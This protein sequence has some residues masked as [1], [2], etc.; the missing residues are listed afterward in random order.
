MRFGQ[1]LTSVSGFD[2][3][4]DYTQVTNFVQG[5]D[6]EFPDG[7]E[8]RFYFCTMVMNEI[9]VSTLPRYA[10]KR[11]LNLLTETW[12][13][14]ARRKS[15][16]NLGDEPYW[17]I[18]VMRSWRPMGMLHLMVHDWATPEFSAWVK[19]AKSFVF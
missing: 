15:E 4:L 10:T 6:Y 14:P 3:T 7:D 1:Q 13:P 16:L 8:Q 5:R 17:Q 18:Q 11:L 12:N 9:R 19:V 2:R